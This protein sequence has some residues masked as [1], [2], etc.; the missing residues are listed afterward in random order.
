MTLPQIRQQLANKLKE[1]HRQ[2]IGEKDVA[3]ALLNDNLKNREHKN[4]TLQAQGDVY[5]AELQRCQVTITHL[6]AR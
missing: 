3:L 1:G 4:V 2:A 6:K 5:Q